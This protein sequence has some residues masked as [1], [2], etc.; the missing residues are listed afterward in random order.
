[1]N[2][3]KCCFQ[4]GIIKNAFIIYEEYKNIS[5]PVQRAIVKFESHT[6]I[7]LIKT[8]IFNGNNFKFEPLSLSDIE[9]KD[10]KRKKKK[11]KTTKKNAADLSAFYLLYLKFM[12]N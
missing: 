3:L 7:S 12:K 4:L 2:S 6:S 10:K 5:D 11:Q 9:F 1:M 8:K